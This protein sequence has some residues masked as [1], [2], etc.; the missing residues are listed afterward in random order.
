VPKYPAE[1]DGISFLPAL[2]GKNRKVTTT[3]TG[4]SRRRWQGRVRMVNWKAVKLNADQGYSDPIGLYDLS[5]M[6]VNK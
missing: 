2:L 5:K 6:R 1:T 3:F 4:S